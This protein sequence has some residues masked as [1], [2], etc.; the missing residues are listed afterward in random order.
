M[1]EKISITSCQLCPRECNADRTKGEGF[2]GGG[3]NI[4]IARAALHQ[5]EEP[6][7]SGKNGSGTV[8]FSGCPLK[9]CFCQNYKISAENYGKE[10][11]IQ[12]L[13]EIF[14]NLQEQNAHN[15]NLVSPTQYVPWIISALDL[16]K[17]Q[18]KI[19][20]VY[21]SG[22]YESIETLRSLRDYIDIYLPDLKYMDQEISKK[23]SNADDYFEVAAA[24]ITEMYNQV[25]GVSFDDDGILKKGMII[26][27]LTLPNNRVD[28]IRIMEWI[29]RTFP[30]N[31]IL[32]SLMSQYTPFYH[33]NYYKEINRRISTFEYNSV[34]DKAVSLGLDGFMQEKSS[35]KE[36]YT[37]EFNLEGI[38]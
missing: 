7:I 4:K 29:S 32:I 28:S 27:H 2:C 21:N 26:R 30:K 15:I 13:A 36:E 3:G 12:H 24:A 16:V 11:T 19:P 23:Y 20:V 17:P 31:D 37:P 1:E 6:C 33:S 10:I 14:L 5:W 25:G 34:V 35:A 8:F 9:C 38:Q 22:G 18:L